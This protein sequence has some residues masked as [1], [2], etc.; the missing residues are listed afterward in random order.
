MAEIVLGMW[1]SHGASLAATAEQA[2]ACGAAIERLA[3]AYAGACPDVA[4]IMGNDEDE[5]FLDDVR[6]A[7]TVFTGSTLW[8][9]PPLPGQLMRAAAAREVTPDHTPGVYTEYPGHPGLAGEIVRGAMAASFDVATSE[10]IVR[11]PGHASGG[12]GQ[13]FGFIYRQ[14]M[15]RRVIPNVPVI[16]NTFFPPNQPTAR[17]CFEFGRLVGRIVRAWDSNA[18]VA[19]FG[20]GGMSHFVIDEEL[21]RTVLQALSERDADAL[22]CID[23]R[24]LQSGSSELKNWIAA[25]GA[26]FESDLRGDVI[27]YQP[28]YRSAAGHGAA[29]GFVC[30]R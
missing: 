2:L 28:C 29:N 27:D 10:L 1:S 21:D 17:R 23:E 30:W 26:L 7:I 5:A 22:C 18:R 4:V 12:I 11:R 15:R 3:D 24:L 9:Q 14:I 16:F 13:A 19:I 25:A 8:N 6:P 20:S